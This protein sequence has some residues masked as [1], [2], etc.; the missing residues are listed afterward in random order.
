MVEW[1]KLEEGSTVNFLLELEAE[2]DE[3]IWTHELKLSE[4]IWRVPE[5]LESDVL[6]VTEVVSMDSEKVTERLSEL[7]RIEVSPSEG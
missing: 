4:E 5:Q 3:D 2:G 7:I 6:V 1:D